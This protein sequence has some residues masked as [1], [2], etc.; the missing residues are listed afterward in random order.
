MEGKP[1][2]K[3]SSSLAAGE[4]IL[5]RLFFIA[6]AVLLVVYAQKVDWEEVWKVI[7]NYNRTVLLG[8]VGLVIVSYLMYGC[9][10]LLGRAYC[11][12]KLAK[13]QVMLVSFICY[14]FNLTL[15]TGGRD[16]YALSPVLPPW[17]TGRHHYAY[18]LLKHNHQ[19]AGV[20]SAGRG[21][22]HHRRGA[23]ACA[24]VHR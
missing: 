2:V 13:R 7:R 23:A 16:W 4:K 11:G 19:L 15:S 12:H 5:T 18:F 3:I 14:A 9:Y 21:D 17:L 8:A 22:F 6:V 1:D 24:L 20:Y 10:D